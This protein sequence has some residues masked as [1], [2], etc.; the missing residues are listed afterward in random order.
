MDSVALHLTPAEPALTY[1]APILQL[2]S[3]DWKNTHPFSPRHFQ[4]GRC[5]GQQRH[6][7]LRRIAE[8]EVTSR[9]KDYGN[10]LR[11]GETIGLFAKRDLKEVVELTSR[12]ST[13][14]VSK[15]KDHFRSGSCTSEQD[16]LLR[17][18]V[19]HPL[20]RHRASR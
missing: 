16:L 17:Q 3:S 20:I 18:L 11:E 8:D 15:A 10:R 6:A 4:I 9:L 5:L 14:A 1:L 2:R 7:L 19:T 13:A 12:I